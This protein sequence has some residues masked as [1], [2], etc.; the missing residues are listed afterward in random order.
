MYSSSVSSKYSEPA[1]SSHGSSS[2]CDSLSEVDSV[3]DMDGIETLLPKNFQRRQQVVTKEHRIPTAKRMKYIATRKAAT[4]RGT[5]AK[6]S[7]RSVR[8]LEGR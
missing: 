4:G 8:M 6:S 7:R 2:L 1:L 5:L 3:D